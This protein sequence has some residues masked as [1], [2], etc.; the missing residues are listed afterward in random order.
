[1]FVLPGYII[2]EHIHENNR[3]NVFRGYTAKDRIPV[4]I[5][6]LKEEAADPLGISRLIH[7][8]E[9]TRNLNIE[10]IIKPIKL[11][12]AGSLFALVMKDI[13]AISLRKHIQR[14]P[15]DLPEFLKIATQLAETLAQ[16]H[17]N[18]II[19]RDLK[20]ENILIHPDTGI[21][22]IIDFS[23]AV[24][25][26]LG[27]KNYLSS[28]NPTGTLEYMAPEQTGRLSVG[29]D[30]RSDLYSLGVVFYEIITGQLPLQAENPA[31]WIHAHITKTPQLPNKV[32]PDI[33]PVISDIIM[34][35]LAKAAEDRY[36]SAYG[37]LWDLKECERQLTQTGRIELF[38]IGRA[39]I[40][41]RFRLPR[42]LYGREKEKEALKA[43]FF[44]ACEGQVETILVSGYPGIGKTMLVNESLKTIVS[45]KGFFIVGKF[46]QLE[47][48]I[49]YAPFAAA[50]GNLIRQLMTESQEELDRW[51]K[52]MLNTLKRNGSVVTGIIPELEW[53]IGKQPPVDVLP[54]KE[55]EN[56]F[57]MVFGDF[58]RLFA[59]KG[60]PLVLFLD[61]LQWA[62]PAS[63]HLLKY[64]S[65][66]ANLH[67]VLFIGAFRE[68][69]VNED[70]PLAEI[71]GES[72]KEYSHEK[73][74]SLMPLE[75]NQAAKLVA[76]TL[77]ELPENITALAEVLYRE[78]GGNPFSLGQLLT[79]LHD[80]GLI[81]FN[82]QEGCWKWEL[83][84]IRKL[85]L[86]DDVL[87]LL[88][89]KLQKLPEGIR[90]IIKLAAC[91]GNRFDMETLVTVSG[92]S[93]E[94]TA[95]CLMPLVLEGLILTVANQKGNLSTA[96]PDK[97]P[98]VF[99]FMH[100][101][102]QQAVYSLILEDEKKEKHIAIGRL[103]LQ[104]TVRSSLEEKIM[105]IMDHFNRSLELIHDPTERME[106]AEYNLLAG[107]KAKASAAYASALQYFRS[108][109]KLLL[110]TAWEHDYKLSYD[111]YLELAQAEYLSGNVKVAEQLFDVVIKKSETE[112]ERASVYG[113]KVILYAGIGKYDNAVKTGINALERLGLKLPIYPKKLDYAKELLLHKWY[114]RNKRIEELASLPEMKDPVQRKIAELLTRLSSVSIISN[115]DFYGYIILKTG[116]HAV[117][118]GNTEMASIGYFGYSITAGSVMGDYEAGD[119][120]GKVCIELVERYGRS[121]SKCIMYFVIGAFI[122]HW[123]RHAA[124]GM[125]YLKKAVHS[126]MEA[127]DVL[128]IGYAHCLILELSYL[129]SIPLE[130][131]AEE[132]REKHDMAR[133]LKHDNFALNVAIYAKL[134]S[135]LQ[136]QKAYSLSSSAEEFQE[137]ELQLP[138][139]DKAS[140]VTFYLCKIQLCYMAG[141]YRDALSAAQNAQPFANAILGFMTS[142]EY[143]FFHSLTIT[144]LYGELSA[145]DRRIYCK[146]L[147]KNQR[148][149]KR[150]SET[151]K[152]NFLHKYLLVAAEIARL[153][154][155]R[156]EAMSLYD[157]AIQSARQNGYIQNEALAN[158]LAARFYLSKGRKK[159][160][161][162]YMLD[163]CHGYNRWGASAK[164]KQLLNRYSDL[165]NGIVLEETKSNSTGIFENIHSISTTSDSEASSGME[166]Y[167]IDKAVESISKETD[168]SKML[169]SFLEIAIQSAGANKGYLILEENGELFIEAAKDNYC[170]EK[171]V[172]AIS[173]EECHELSKAVVRYVARTLETIVL[174]SG[175]QAGIFASD[176]YI[177]ESNSKSIACLPL[178]LQGIP[179]GVLYLENS[180]M[181]GVF[182]AD[183]LE[184]LKLL[185]TQVVFIKK[186]QSYLEED[187]I[188]T[189]DEAYSYLIE[190]LTERETE[191]LTLISVGM[192]N[193][194]IADRL[195]MTVNTV[196]THI[197][198][199]YGKL[200]VNR[201]VQAVERAKKLGVL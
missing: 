21:G 193:K 56:R 162:M 12:Q 64:L 4:I 35:L 77:Y 93:W 129:L 159:I 157:Q 199:I 34:K 153:Q 107:R 25:F 166:T 169:D 26:T 80:E 75:W 195:E 182:A 87:E 47:R 187:N 149:M 43:A 144:A 115:P 22:H 19:H 155:R 31:E 3:I 140:L 58:I 102:I 30:Q 100:D 198:N 141:N 150:W 163:A 16:L 86:G 70:H 23:S 89:K 38:P 148:K 178:S 186:L 181:P 57:L 71:L 175:E 41:V 99:E 190:T 11:E 113:L 44:R 27:S 40:F 24:L 15:V 60:H 160:A 20:P 50:F 138:Q 132:V 200:Q 173:L 49:P 177:A 66:D 5:K 55:A 134:V 170:N 9:I 53:I 106:L 123:T 109:I 161:R 167:I 143:N 168:L 52:R 154:D 184:V 48:N 117:R 151:C 146:I 54:P 194:E 124:F 69:E 46:D 104:N 45:E 119:R 32:N 8:F 72:S 174:N 28:N 63:I 131:I 188:K 68:N 7:E 67:S 135:A 183:Q 136:G 83:E 74:I 85:H 137:E 103:L 128:I 62:D 105:Y 76:E 37:L 114:M 139:N 101:R 191:V 61:D 94:E 2:Y 111:L 81:Y 82:T 108:G 79:L 172:K 116:N 13:G 192:S 18:G 98:S 156:D 158:E 95:S 185:S 1:M 6:A 73:H 197:K 164:V 171:T 10:G 29:I 196:K 179:I 17:Q 91:I 65:R 125:E 59:R 121:S 126:G 51:K 133:R 152:E 176:P 118:Y 90:E 122:I 180:L 127:G 165:L 39:D 84:A 78:S 112:L 33:L 130:K 110:D 88:L 14:H 36:Q 145:R 42:K 92:S 142:A 120:F 97:E 189:K 147:K 201:R 96:Y